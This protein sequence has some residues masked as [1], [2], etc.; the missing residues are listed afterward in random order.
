[1]RCSVSVRAR[2]FFALALRF[3]NFR[4]KLNW[5]M[6][7]FLSIFEWIV[8]EWQSRDHWSPFRSKNLKERSR[9][10]LHKPAPP[11]HRNQ[12]VSFLFNFYVCSSSSGYRSPSTHT[13]SHTVRCNKHWYFIETI[14]SKEK[15]LDSPNY[16]LIGK[17]AKRVCKIL[18]KT[19]IIYTSLRFIKSENQ[20]EWLHSSRFSLPPALT[21]PYWWHWCGTHLYHSLG[22]S[23]HLSLQMESWITTSEDRTRYGCERV[24]RI[25]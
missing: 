11:S 5:N 13:R 8:G 9:R 16:L 3:D 25:A 24:I 23:C 2:L 7:V 1:M 6:P 19:Q 12:W 4:D 10:V 14:K 22:D 15:K 21:A 20:F 18:K 17:C